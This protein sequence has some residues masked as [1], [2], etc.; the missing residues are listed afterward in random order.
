LFTQN[1]NL[2]DSFTRDQLIAE[3]VSYEPYQFKI[4][5]S[6]KIAKDDSELDKELGNSVT[7]YE[8]PESVSKTY[9][10]QEFEKDDDTNWHIAFVTAAANLRSTNYRILTSSF[11]KTKGIAGRIVPAVATTTSI[12][13]GLISME[14]LKY[15]YFYENLPEDG[16]VIERYKSWFVS[17]ANNIFVSSEPIAAPMLKFGTT[18]INSWTKFELNQDMT[19]EKF[20]DLY[21]DKFKTKISMVL[22]G[23]SIIFAEFIPSNDKSKLMSLIFKEKYEIDLFTKNAEVVIA[24]DDDTIELPTIELK[25]NKTVTSDLS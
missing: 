18:E 21:E 16:K 4:D 15:C 5:E 14:I 23:T 25:M 19:L 6:K 7:E 2:D 11:S 24:S 9:R 13:A 22:H 1:C 17:L 12:V 3:L 10:V 20:I 8:I